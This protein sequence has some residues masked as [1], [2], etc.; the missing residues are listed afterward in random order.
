MNKKDNI[1]IFLGRDGVINKNTGSYITKWRQFKFMP[2]IFS[3]LKVFK[4]RGY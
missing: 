4:Q 1:T 3:V 2:H